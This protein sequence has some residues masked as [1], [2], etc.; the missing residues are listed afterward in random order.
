MEAGRSDYGSSK[1][2]KGARWLKDLLSKK[3]EPEENGPQ[4]AAPELLGVV[5]E[6]VA[7]NRNRLTDIK[8]E[9]EKEKPTTNG[10][11]SKPSI[12]ESSEDS[13]KEEK[14]TEKKYSLIIVDVS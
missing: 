2:G 9:D 8:E 12:I 11:G 7:S 13:E 1:G 14:D 6:A 4:D 10:H 3:G 5:E